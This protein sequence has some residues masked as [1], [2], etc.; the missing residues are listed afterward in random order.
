MREAGAVLTSRLTFLFWICCVRGTLNYL[1]AYIGE[2][3]TITVKCCRSG[4]KTSSAFR[5]ISF[6]GVCWCSVLNVLQRVEIRHQRELTIILLKPNV[7]R[8]WKMPSQLEK[9]SSMKGCRRSA[10]I[11]TLVAAPVCT[12][13]QIVDPRSLMWRGRLNTF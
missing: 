9:T 5:A 4:T 11:F 3:A 12:L 10:I 6:G 13:P 1:F 8:S 2:N 7:A